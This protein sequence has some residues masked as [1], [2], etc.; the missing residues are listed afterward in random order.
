MRAVVTGGAGFIGSRL[1][2]QLVNRGWVVSVIDNF[3]TG[4][5]SNLE[6][7][8]CEVH[9]AC[10]TSNNLPVIEHDV[11]FHLASPVSVPES[12]DNPEKYYLEIAD[13]TI[14][15]ARWSIASGASKIILAST[16]AIYGESDDLPFGEM[17]AQNCESPYARSKW[18]AE[19]I[20]RDITIANSNTTG[21][22]LRFFNVFGEGQRKDGGY[23]SVIPIFRELWDAGEPLTINGDG[24]QT[25]DF[26]WVEDVVR[27]IV[28][29]STNTKGTYN[30]YN[31]GSGEET[32]VNQIAESF[33]SEV[34]YLPE[35][36]EPKRSLAC[37]SKIYEDLNWKPTL[38]IENW[39]ETI[40]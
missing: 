13:G 36:D 15:I 19:M 14:N 1:V 4:E 10:V 6:G 23:R 5:W 25:R 39:I 33:G 18:L 9:E 12:H 7:L 16:A 21:T 8:D 40:R 28:S 35:I 31:V 17:R 30:V 27:A 2:E 3:S 34:K 11:L 29:A 38:P 37:I 32:S 26:I 24:K 22:S 20:I